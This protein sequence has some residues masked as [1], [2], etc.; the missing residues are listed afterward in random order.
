MNDE[1]F[2]GDPETIDWNPG[3]KGESHLLVKDSIG[4]ILPIATF[5]Q[6]SPPKGRQEFS[7]AMEK[8]KKRSSSGPNRGF[9]AMVILQ[10]RTIAGMTEYG[11]AKY[12]DGTLEEYCCPFWA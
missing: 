10:K 8:A 6:K 3:T 4:E 11:L 9:S 1:V 5:T 2:P 12:T 7:T